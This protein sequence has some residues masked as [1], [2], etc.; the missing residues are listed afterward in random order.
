VD[1]LPRL[2]AVEVLMVGDLEKIVD[3]VIEQAQTYVEQI[4]AM[5]LDSIKYAIT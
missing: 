2:A 1:N 4:K 5:N 3:D